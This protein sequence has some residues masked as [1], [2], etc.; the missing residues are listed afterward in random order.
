MLENKP[1]SLA[2]VYILKVEPSEF[3]DRL[4]VGCK[5]KKRIKNDFNMFSS[6][7]YLTDS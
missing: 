1:E 4:N 3:P 5:R 7:K 2:R 6:A